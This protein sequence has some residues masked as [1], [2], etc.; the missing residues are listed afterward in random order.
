MEVFAAWKADRKSA[1]E[2]EDGWLNPIARLSLRTGVNTIGSGPE[3][4]LRL[5]HG[6]SLLGTIDFGT[7]GAR[8]A[9]PG[10][11]PGYFEPAPGGFPMVRCP[12]FLLELHD[13][14]GDPALRVRDLTLPRGVVLDYFPYDPAWVIEAE[15]AAMDTPTE[16][17]IGQSGAP[18]T[19]VAVSHEARFTHRGHAIRLLPTH[20]KNG[21]PMFVIRDETSGRKT[22]AASRFLIPEPARDGKITLDFNRLHNPPCA[23]T[24]HA[25]CPLPP[26]S[27]VLPFAVTAGELMPDL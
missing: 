1:L 25:I 13:P 2:A 4:D 18:D 21:N 20:W 7:D 17:E 22:Y 16:I 26:R 9:A 12:P 6:P 3:C 10:G 15:W 27:N 24:D 23:F 8:F 5:P 11:A 19:A 14:G